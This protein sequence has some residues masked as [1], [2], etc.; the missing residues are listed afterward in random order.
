MKIAIFL[1]APLSLLAACAV[2]PDM[3]GQTELPTCDKLVLPPNC[4]NAPGSGPSN[5]EVNFNKNSL[6]LAPRNVCAHKGTTLKFKITPSAEAKNPP[7][8]VAVIP[9]NGKDTWLT[10]T[11]SSNNGEIEIQIPDYLPIN[12]YYDYTVVSVMNGT[13]SCVDPRINVIN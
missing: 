13:V 11:N 10:G 7:G 3:V 12:S 5:P 6:L 4:S 8:S 9:K 1:M 2:S